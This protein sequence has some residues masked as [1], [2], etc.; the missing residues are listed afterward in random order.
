MTISLKEITLRPSTPNDID[1]ILEKHISLYYKEFNYPPIQ[2]GKHVSEGLLPFRQQT[3]PGHLWIAEYTP[4]PPTPTSNANT[5]RL[6]WAGC[7]AVV[8]TDDDSTGRLRFMLVA[9]KF[10]SCGL[11]RKLLETAL[12]YCLD[13]GYSRVTLSTTGDCVGAHRLYTLFGFRQ[14]EVTRGYFGEKVHMNGGK[15]NSIRIDMY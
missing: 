2:F 15:S 13:K 5:A 6:E 4:T 8:P 3:P 14:V 11:G 9:P 12:E 10:R 1:I 7:V